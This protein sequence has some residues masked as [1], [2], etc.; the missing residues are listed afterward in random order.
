MN[1][2]SAFIE[3]LESHKNSR[4]N[5]IAKVVAEE[6][7]DRDREEVKIWFE[8]LLYH[9]CASGMVSSMI[10]YTDTHAFFDKYYDEIMQIKEDYEEEIGQPMNI[11]TTLKNYLAWFA[12]EEVARTLYAHFE[13]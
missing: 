7:L 12:Y 5:T 2:Q 13:S 10:Y 1:N 8:D 9:G 11:P 3:F 6:A 4:E